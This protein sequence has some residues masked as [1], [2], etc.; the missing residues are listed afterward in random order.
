MEEWKELRNRIKESARQNM[1]HMSDDEV[2]EA[3]EQIAND[4]MDCLSDNFR[5]L[6]EIH[7]IVAGVRAGENVQIAYADP[8]EDDAFDECIVRACW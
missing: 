3:A 2:N 5:S 8:D 7:Q 1:K 6:T 4:L